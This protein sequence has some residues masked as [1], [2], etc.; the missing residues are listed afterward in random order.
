MRLGLSWIL[1]LL[2]LTAS[3]AE[4]RL[5]FGKAG[6]NR[7]P[8][9]FRSTVT[10]KGKPGEWKVLLEDTAPILAPVTSEAPSVSRRAVL[11]QVAKDP[12]D[13]HYPLLI[14]D[15]EVFADFKLTTQ[16]KI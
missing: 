10:G 14:Y 7:L 15:E 13:D 8:A 5:D 9:G 6:E 16:F 1:M 3:A 11:A 4:R 2:V 12:T